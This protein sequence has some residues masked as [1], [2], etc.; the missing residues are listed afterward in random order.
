MGRRYRKRLVNDDE[1]VGYSCA[2]CGTLFC[3]EQDI[4][5]RHFHGKHG[6]AIL[7]DSCVNYYTGPKESK[8]L[9]TGTHIVREV[10]CNGCDRNIG[11]CYDYAFS[12]KSGI[13]F[14]ASFWS[15]L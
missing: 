6:Q 14:N 7:V 12:E 13:K 15:A 3:L 8:V 1:P 5:S 11:W 2:L 4:I 9:M 10:F